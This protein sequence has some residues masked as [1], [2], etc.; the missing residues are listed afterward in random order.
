MPLMMS[1]NS[2]FLIKYFI[3]S[4]TKAFPSLACF[5]D[6]GREKQYW[7]RVAK[8]GQR[9]LLMFPINNQNKKLLLLGED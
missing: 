1:L 9:Y 2:K 6:E 5:S 7:I 8:L 4:V 3:K